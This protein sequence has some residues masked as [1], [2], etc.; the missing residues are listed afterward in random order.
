MRRFQPLILIVIAF[1]FSLPAWS[2]SLEEARQ[3]HEEGKTEEA[4]AAIE[5]LLSSGAAEA[6]KAAALDLLGTIAVDEGQLAMARQAWSRLVDEYPDY[7]KSNDTATK[8][9]LVS[10]L[11]K[12]D[13]APAVSDTTPVESVEEEQS[14]APVVAREQER[15]EPVDEPTPV[16]VP[17][18]SPPTSTPEPSAPAEAAAPA[19]S[20]APSPSSGRVLI[21]ARGKPHDAVR[22]LSSRIVEHLREMGVDAE[23]AT[24][25]IP[26]VEDSSM[27]LPMLLQKGQTE[28]VGS[29]LLLSANFVAMQKVALD[30]YTPT[31]A[32]IWKLKVSGGTG[33]T[34]R[35]YSKSGITEKL[36]ERF[37]EKLDKKVGDPCLPAT[38]K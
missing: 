13:E 17:T 28:G 32:K 27:V 5:S 6:E 25:G 20:V 21:A 2:A 26:V 16:P 14:V 3:L 11:L 24:G 10:A 1:V 22:Q 9:S 12:T 38:L 8:L 23:S 34:G 37:M 15:D 29:V 30:C 18:A 35:P 36:A 4:L 31:G 19:A 7:A 33:F